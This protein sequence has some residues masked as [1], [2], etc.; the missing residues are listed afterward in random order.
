VLRR[1]SLFFFLFFTGK[2][3][4]PPYALG[5]SRRELLLRNK[6]LPFVKEMVP[7]GPKFP[8]SV[9][10]YNNYV[11]I[12]E[13]LF[14]TAGLPYLFP[15]CNIAWSPR[16]LPP[17]LLT[18][19]RPRVLVPAHPLSHFSFSSHC[20]PLCSGGSASGG[21]ITAI[22]LFFLSSDASPVLFPFLFS[23]PLPGF[24]PL[25]LAH[26][27]PRLC[28]LTISLTGQRSH[29]PLLG[30]IWCARDRPPWNIPRVSAHGCSFFFRTHCR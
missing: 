20:L 12:D 13:T 2:T 18:C 4:P 26:V 11:T 28:F 30:R 6:N 29:F 7:F 5:T 17:P 27:L 21:W 3:Y 23:E 1:V 24:G 9:P 15:F 8:V 25:P 19:S 22:I 14:F 10:F 16:P